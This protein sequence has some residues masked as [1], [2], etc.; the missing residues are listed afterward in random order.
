MLHEANSL[1]QFAEH[2]LNRADEDVVTFLAC[3]NIKRGINHLLLAYLTAYD[4]QGP[5]EETTDKLLNICST[6]DPA[7]SKL[8]MKPLECS[9]E[10]GAN[11]FCTSTDHVRECLDLAKQTK[12]LVAR[13]LNVA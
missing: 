13:N 5:M 9:H 10:K 11:N 3:N 2:E 6:I 7:F 8:N 4:V 12:M 1:I